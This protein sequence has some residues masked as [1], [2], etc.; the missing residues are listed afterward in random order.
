MKRRT[1]ACT[2]ATLARQR[3][4]PVKVC[5]SGYTGFTHRFGLRTDAMSG[6]TS[7]FDRGV[8]MPRKTNSSYGK[9]KKPSAASA[10]GGKGVS[11]ERRV[12]AQR[13]L[14]MCMGQGCFGIP[15]GFRVV[16]LIFQARVHN[17]NTDDLVCK[18][19]DGYGNSAKVLMQMKSELSPGDDAFMEAVGLAWHDFKAGTVQPGV[20]RIVIAYDIASGEKMRSAADI[21]TLARASTSSATFNTKATAADVSNAKK[22][23]ALTAITQAVNDF[24][25]GVPATEE[26]VFQF[27]RHLHFLHQDF[28]SDSTEAVVACCQNIAL[29]TRVSGR[30]PLA[31]E[32]VWAKL[33]AVCAELNGV[34]SEVNL[35]NVAFQLDHDLD[36]RFK[37][38]RDGQAQ[39]MFNPLVVAIE[40]ARTLTA[41]LPLP[42]QAATAPKA[43]S[44]QGID[45]IP[46]AR[47][48]SVNKIV[49][50]RLDSIA[51]STRKGLYANAL[52]DLTELGQDFDAFDVHQK[53]RWHLIH[54]TS[55]WNVQSAVAEAADEFLLAA[56]LCDDD[57]KLAAARVRGHLLKGDAATALVA[58]REARERFPTSLTV[59]VSLTNARVLAG[60]TV[61]VQDIPADFQNEAAAFDVVANAY[62]QAGDIEKALE[63]TLAALDKNDASFFTREAALRYQL[64]IATKNPLNVL[65]RARDVKTVEGMQRL[66]REFTPRDEKLWAIQS[67]QHVSAAATHLAWMYVLLGNPEETVKIAAEV[68][69]RRVDTEGTIYRAQ[70]EAMRYL[71]REPDALALT[72][73]HVAEMPAD[74][75]VSFAQLSGELQDGDALQLAVAEASSRVNLAERRGELLV[76]LDVIR[77]DMLLRSGDSGKVRSECERIGVLQGDSFERTVVGARAFLKAPDPVNAEPYIERARVLAKESDKPG[78]SY[79]LAQ[80]LMEAGDLREAADVLSKAL[81]DKTFSE[82]H[83]DLLYCYVRTGQRA[84]ARTLIGSFPADWNS[85]RKARHLALELGQSAGD[86]ALLKSLIPGQLTDSPTAAM[87]WLLRIYV[88][89]RESASAVA[90]ALREIP[91][92]LTGSVRE[93][94][95]LASAELRGGQLEAGLRHL[96]RLRRTN[97]G[98]LEAAA[99]YFTAMALAPPDLPGLGE[100]LPEVVP[101]ASVFL[102]NEAGQGFWRTVDPDNMPDLVP[103][104]EFCKSESAEGTRLL[105]LKPGDVLVNRGGFGDESRF[106]VQQVTSAYRRLMVLANEVLA[107]PGAEAAP[108]GRVSMFD[109]A[110]KFTTEPI[111]KRLQAQASQQ[112]NVFKLY[113]TANYTLGA[114]GRMLGADEFQLV[115]GWPADGPFLHVGGGSHVDRAVATNN[116]A[117]ASCSVVDLSALVE[118][119]QLNQLGVL[120]ALPNPM[121]TSA[122]RD[123]IEQE[124]SQLDSSLR[125][126]R[127]FLHEGKL[128]FMEFDGESRAQERRFLESIRNAV[129]E[130]TT[131]I[132]AC[133][134]ADVND[135]LEK[136]DDIVSGPEYSSLLA[137]LEHRALLVSLDARML[138]FAVSLGLRGV[139]LQAMLMSMR[140]AGHITRLAYAQATISSLLRRRS[141]VSID[142]FDL[143]VALYQGQEPMSV[144]L[145]RLREYLADAGT[146][147]AS[148]WNVVEAFL[149]RLNMHGTTQFGAFLELFGYCSRRCFTTRIAPKISTSRRSRGSKHASKA[150]QLSRESRRSFILRRAPWLAAN[151]PCCPLN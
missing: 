28:D 70:I 101:G 38:F 10:S 106:T 142:E 51:A 30:A 93:L 87:S 119:A 1:F 98:D 100:K 5:A 42:Q 63:L 114:L 48:A 78:A 84:K 112:S 36:F 3:Q 54:A 13:L 67:T 24:N 26:G 19:E 81:A 34:G 20:D 39:S 116:L 15:P 45:I 29:A 115:R 52:R 2:V 27:L 25:E 9:Q 69:D 99:A 148:A 134:P 17:F 136:V 14:A 22:R 47:E 141:F 49:S 55:I 8:G 21:A 61:Q 105:G 68:A 41:T 43:G 124:L 58:A 56:N 133:G 104:E 95:Q 65:F 103:T 31:P 60:E 7:V 11:F 32:H 150:Q 91:E 111:V 73:P 59:W 128:G 122:T 44:S 90:I 18:V 127:M 118:L 120:A 143:E 123:F 37:V 121:V 66:A 12:Q 57:D 6:W 50:R 113:E 97:L 62:R 109:E 138:I 125:G 89:T 108:I 140:N 77:W 80:L 102:V 79:L 92:V 71:H 96:Y 46:T 110:G 126:G 129:K 16:E 82:P 83:V 88:A 64:E 139:W 137:A 147:F 145:N 4:T 76:T 131:V 146:E 33:V 132:P 117:E 53:A 130:H 40:E 75:L 144:F 135:V 149:V 86:W 94:T 74:T 35:G 72:K 151:T 107:G 85:D 23:K